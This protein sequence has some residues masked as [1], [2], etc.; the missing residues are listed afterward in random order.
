MLLPD[1]TYEQCQDILTPFVALNCALA[2]SEFATKQD[3]IANI[4]NDGPAQQSRLDGSHASRSDENSTDEE[5]DDERVDTPE[6]YDETSEFFDNIPDYNGEPLRPFSISNSNESSR[7]NADLLKECEM[8]LCKYRI[9]P[10]F[11]CR[12]RNALQ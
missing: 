9:R 6:S 4:A 8:F 10:D 2:D 5:T 3:K 1:Q 11:F 7:T 12:Y